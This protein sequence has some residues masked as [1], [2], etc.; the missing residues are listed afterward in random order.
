MTERTA[1]TRGT[2]GAGTS[3]TDSGARTTGSGA[4]TTG[5]GTAEAAEWA[6]R[7]GLGPAA[8]VAAIAAVVLGGG[9]A[10]SLL[11]A[12]SKP[13]AGAPLGRLPGV[14]LAAVA[15]APAIAHIRAGGNPPSDVTAAVV[16]P[17]GSVYTGR[18]PYNG[19]SQYS[20][21]IEVRVGA[22]ASQVASFYRAELSHLG[23]SQ[24]ETVAPASGTGKEILARHASSDGWYWGIGVTVRS[25]SP[26][27]APALAGADQHAP[28]STLSLSLY[29]IA[30]AG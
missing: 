8:I 16:L 21:T 15:A 27:I 26:L 4:R 5:T 23:W 19:V 6:P 22:T 29:E 20:A 3:T 12:S 18:R 11:T 14:G 7:P 30:D 24:I 25:S 2:T 28:T 13:V 1:I 9:I 10:A 17:S